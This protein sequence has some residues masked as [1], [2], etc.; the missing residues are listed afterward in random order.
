MWAPTQLV[1]RGADPQGKVSRGTET[2][3]D[4]LQ[5]E[6]GGVR[7]V[8]SDRNKEAFA[9]DLKSVCGGGWLF[10]FFSFVWS[11]LRLFG[12]FCLLVGRCCFVFW[13]VLVCFLLKVSCSVKETSL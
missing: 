7:T 5:Q 6:S 3:S 4:L 8:K 13:F 11:G 12:V 1:P 9:L 2:W 10:G